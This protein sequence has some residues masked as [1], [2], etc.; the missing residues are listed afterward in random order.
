MAFSVDVNRLNQMIG[1]FGLNGT[2]RRLEDIAENEGVSICKDQYSGVCRVLGSP[3]DLR[4]MDFDT[5]GGVLISLETPQEN[6]L[7]VGVDV[8]GGG[9]LAL[10]ANQ[11]EDSRAIKSVKPRPLLVDAIWEVAHTYFDS[12]RDFE[13]CLLDP[14]M[15]IWGLVRDFPKATCQEAYAAASLQTSCGEV[16]GLLLRVS[17]SGEVTR[18][19]YPGSGGALIELLKGDKDQ[20]LRV[21]LGTH[22]FI[23]EKRGDFETGTCRI[24][25]SFDGSGRSGGYSF[26]T[27]LIRDK[28]LPTAEMLRHFEAL[29]H[30]HRYRTGD[31]RWRGF[32][33]AC[34]V[35]FSSTVDPVMNRAKDQPLRLDLEIPQ[36]LR[37]PEEVSQ[38]LVAELRGRSELYQEFHSGDLS[39]LISPREFHQSKWPELWGGN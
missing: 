11:S 30:C 20:I 7:A 16:S 35:L 37:E 25:Q 15:A 23:I 36:G 14:S 24:Y 2:R 26:E 31:P 8:P 29:I 12:L 33:Q 34:R 28:P 32:Q 27:A 3:K 13:F 22:S 21:Q 9:V 18:L 5:L 38:L 17:G 19:R 4:E 6:R 10:R 39:G 1:Q